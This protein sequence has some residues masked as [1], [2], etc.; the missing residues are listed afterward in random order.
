MLM[1]VFLK[2]L[3]LNHQTVSLESLL[4]ICLHRECLLCQH[5]HEINFH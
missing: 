3:S 5:R 4:S 1:F 2:T